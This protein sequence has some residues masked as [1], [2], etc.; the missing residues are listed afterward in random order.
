LTRARDGDG[1]QLPKELIMTGILSIWVV[2]D[3]P[4][5]FPEW[6]IVRRQ[7]PHADGT[8]EYDPRAYGFADLEKAR[9]WLAQQ[10]LTCLARQPKDDPAIIETWL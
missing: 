6:F 9:A 8:I 3:H 10:G 1:R 7:V 4:L 2:F 5:D